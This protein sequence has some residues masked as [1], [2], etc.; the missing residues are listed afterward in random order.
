M[1]DE[2]TTGRARPSSWSERLAVTVVLA[3]AL[4]AAGFGLI[5]WP[6]Y[7]EV[8]DLRNENSRLRQEILVVSG[9]L[10]A[11]AVHSALPATR[12]RAV[13][14]AE[15]ANAA[16]LQELRVGDSYC[17]G[18]TYIGFARG[19]K[20]LM[21]LIARHRQFEREEESELLLRLGTFFPDAHL[22]RADLVHRDEWGFF[23]RDPKTG[24]VY[25]CHHSKSW[26]S[27]G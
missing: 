24:G 8:I 3:F 10:V 9:L 6:L 7:R 16:E 26:K 22:P 20:N 2:Q 27:G 11:G 19:P 1:S 4:A 21:D 25:F 14:G 13:V 12:L 5:L 23:Y 17:D 18:H 15:A